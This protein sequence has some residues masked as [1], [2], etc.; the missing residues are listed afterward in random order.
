[1]AID[2][3]TTAELRLGLGRMAAGCNTLLFN[4]KLCCSALVV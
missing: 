1:M 3:T 4:H 2:S